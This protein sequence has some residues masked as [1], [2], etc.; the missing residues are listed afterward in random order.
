MTWITTYTGKTFD[1][2]NPTPEMIDIADIAHS[3]AAQVRFNG[4]TLV[5]YSIGQHSMGVATWVFKE[6]Q[7]KAIA[8]QGLLHDATEAY[9]GDL[10]SP[11]KELIPDFKQIEKRIWAVIAT[12]FGVP[13]ELHP[14]VKETD[15]RI[16]LTER[17]H[18]LNN[19]RTPA[20]ELDKH[21]APLPVQT[22]VPLPFVEVRKQFMGL[23]YF[24]VNT[25]EHDVHQS[26]III[27]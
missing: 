11:L 20:W 27:P 16:L 26:R 4:H 3:L 14:M 5:P 22:I 25:A 18:L 9:V 1:F 19:E 2:V 21:Y 23:F 17:N 10:V 15:L 6:L 8:L 7:D 12:K 24:F 13:I